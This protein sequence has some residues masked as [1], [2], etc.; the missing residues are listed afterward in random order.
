MTVS[1]D[2]LSSLTHIAVRV[3][4]A[5]VN[6]YSDRGENQGHSYAVLPT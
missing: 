1:I 6:G 5:Y 4:S 3:E 2:R